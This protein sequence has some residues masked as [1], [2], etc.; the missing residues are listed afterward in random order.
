MHMVDDHE[1]ASSP[2]EMKGKLC[3]CMYL[4]LLP[5]EFTTKVVFYLMFGMV[6][7]YLYNDMNGLEDFS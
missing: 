3:V 6:W 4:K 5:L 7:Q 2:V 1:C